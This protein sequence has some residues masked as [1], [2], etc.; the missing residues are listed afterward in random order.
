MSLCLF[1]LS[2]C[3]SLYSLCLSVS[4][5]SMSLCLSLSLSLCVSLYSLCLSRSVCL[6]ILPVCLSLSLCLLSLCLSLCHCPCSVLLVV[7]LSPVCLSLQCSDML[8]SL[9]L[10]LSLSFPHPVASL[11]LCLCSPCLCALCLSVSLCLCLSLSL[12]LLVYACL[13]LSC[14]SVSVYLILAVSIAG[15][16]PSGDSSLPGDHQQQLLLARLNE[17][18]LMRQVA[19]EEIRSLRLERL[20]G[21]FQIKQLKKLLEEARAASIKDERQAEELQRQ[22]QL[23]AI[24]D[25]LLS[26]LPS[27]ELSSAQLRA[28]SSHPTTRNSCSRIFLLSLCFLSPCLLNSPIC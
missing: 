1:I 7:L 6:F 9:S 16:L 24:K 8:L 5:F 4:L 18:A 28:V 10:C 17:A 27:L 23:T 14:V 19:E 25:Q 3:L 2:V 13:S 20:Q 26:R 21:D 15:S 11:S 22:L 12:P